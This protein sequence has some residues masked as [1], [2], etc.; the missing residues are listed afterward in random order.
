MGGRRPRIELVDAQ[1]DDLGHAEAS[2]VGKM[3]HSSVTEARGRTPIWGVE[4]RLD[5]VTA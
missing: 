1:S 5:L 2:G 4:Q 3:K